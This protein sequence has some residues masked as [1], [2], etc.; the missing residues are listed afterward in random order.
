ME[1]I[2]CSLEEWD[3]ILNYYRPNGSSKTWYLK[4]LKQLH[5]PLM[6]ANWTLFSEDGDMFNLDGFKRTITAPYS[7]KIEYLTSDKIDGRPHIYIINVGDSEFFKKN[8]Q[9]GFSCVSENYLNDVRNGKSVIVLFL[10]Y[11]GYSGIRGNFDFEIIEDW[12]KGSNLPEGSVYYV[13]GN[14][15]SEEIVKKRNLG[16][17]GRGLHY[18]EPWNKYN[19]EIVNFNPIDEKHLFLSYNRQPRQHR[20][21]LA[22]EL[23]RTNLFDKGLISLYKLHGPLP[24]AT[25]LENDFLVNNSP[26]TIDSKYDLYYNLA[27][28]ITKEDYEKTFISLLTETLVDDGTLFL[29][30]KIWKPIMVGHPFL[31]Y[32]NKGTLK[33]LKELGYKTFDRWIDESYDDIDDREL[34]C[35]KIVSELKKFSTKTTDEL[36]LVREEMKEICQYNQE[37]FKM[38]YKTNYDEHANSFKIEN[39]LNEIWKK[40]K[41][42]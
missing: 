2:I 4:E 40:I 26:F 38:L 6:W 35:S 32:G 20:I 37:H 18:F 9:I 5:L 13:C 7:D 24:N 36:K 25:Q 19:E 42:K 31:V 34:R 22:I 3:S 16:I 33:Y 14:L 41:N 8:N 27:I 11:E 23:I 17:E 29:S 1:K 39:I 28:N 21:R 12:R 15:L 10:P 30:E